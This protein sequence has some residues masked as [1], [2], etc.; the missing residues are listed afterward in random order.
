MELYH[1]E[2]GVEKQL[3]HKADINNIPL[4][5]ALELLPLCNMDCK[6]CYVKQTKEEMHTQ[7]RLLSCEEWLDIARQGV[8]H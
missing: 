2:E 1:V 7:G 3:Q 6:M 4:G 5:G 8:Q